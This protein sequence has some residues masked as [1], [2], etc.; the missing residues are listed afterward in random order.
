MSKVVHFE[1]PIDDPERASA[2]YGEAFGWEISGFGEMAYWLARAGDA[3]ESGADGALIARGGLH[4]APVL[5][6]AVED[7]DEALNRIERLSG[8]ILQ[9]KHPIPTVGWSAYIRDSE[10]NTI[11]IFQSDPNAAG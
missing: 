2:F 3:S 4:E 10:G 11:G 7:I 9:G 5:V 1:I 6:V 8:T